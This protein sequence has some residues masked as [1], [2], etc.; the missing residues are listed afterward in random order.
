MKEIIHPDQSDMRNMAG[1]IMMFFINATFC[2]IC[3]KAE[4]EKYKTS[5]KRESSF[6]CKYFTNWK[7]ATVQ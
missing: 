7:D 2:Y 6:I 5:N 4:R 1:Y 3:I